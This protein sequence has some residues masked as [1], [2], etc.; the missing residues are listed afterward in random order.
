MT[1]RGPLDHRAFAAASYV[2]LAIVF[3]TSIYIAARGQLL[4]A[5]VL[6]ALVAGGIVFIAV[7]DRLPSI[8]TLLFVLAGLFN[9]LGFVLELW[10]TPI[11]FDEFVHVYAPFSVTAGLGWLLF[12]RSAW[13]P[14]QRP[15][16][17]LAYVAGLGIAIGVG[18]ELFEL[19]IGIIGSTRDTVI[20]LLCDSAG[21]IAAGVFCVWAANS[22]AR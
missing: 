16:R 22:G 21:A 15:L 17:F 20:D 8:F 1:G 6:L 11:W 9:A 7:R 14:R 5:L 3:A 18:W 2:V 13:K 4:E 12:Y 10:R 19:A